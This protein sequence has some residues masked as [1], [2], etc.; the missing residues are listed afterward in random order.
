[1]EIILESIKKYEKVMFPGSFSS[2]N[3]R[4]WTFNR[5]MSMQFEP[6]MVQGPVAGDV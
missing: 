1:M 6:I 5:H 2:L 4:G 3:P